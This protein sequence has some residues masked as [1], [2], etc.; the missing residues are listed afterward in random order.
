[1]E[2]PHFTTGCVTLPPCPSFVHYGD[3]ADIPEEEYLDLL[4][5]AECLVGCLN[6]GIDLECFEAIF[7]VAVKTFVKKGYLMMYPEFQC[8]KDS[9]M[10][11]LKCFKEKF[12]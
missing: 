5:S 10:S 11:T 8:L 7:R 12:L 1:M 4:C 9:M 2:S 6:S 3:L